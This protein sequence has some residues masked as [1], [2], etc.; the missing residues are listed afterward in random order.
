MASYVYDAFS[1]AEHLGKGLKADVT[2]FGLDSKNKINWRCH[3]SLMYSQSLAISEVIKQDEGEEQY[4]Q[5]VTQQQSFNDIERVCSHTTGM[6]IASSLCDNDIS[7]S[8][9]AAH[10]YR[11]LPLVGCSASGTR[12]CIQSLQ[13]P[14][15][16]AG[17]PYCWQCDWHFWLLHA[18][19]L[20]TSRF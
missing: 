17:W 15:P 8:F 16:A 2:S 19:Y 18:G 12:Q 6:S 20:V 11:C 7:R 1:H 14:G 5:A 13:S 4:S 3:L 9:I 10:S